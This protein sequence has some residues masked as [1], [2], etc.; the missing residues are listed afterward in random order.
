[1]YVTEERKIVERNEGFKREDKK[2]PFIIIHCHIL[3]CITLLP[4]PK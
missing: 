4:S 2:I 1:M 3:R